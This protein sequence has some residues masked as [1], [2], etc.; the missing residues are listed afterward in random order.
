MVK[1]KFWLGRLQTLSA[2]TQRSVEKNAEQKMAEQK[3][4]GDPRGA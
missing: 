1:Q 3:F 4:G 2:S